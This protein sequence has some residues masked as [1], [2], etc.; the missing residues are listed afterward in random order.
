MSLL[1]LLHLPLPLHLPRRFQPE[2]QSMSM[3]IL[4][5]LPWNFNGRSWKCCRIVWYLVQQWAMRP[6]LLQ[7]LRLLPAAP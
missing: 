4:G 6:L 7:S 2:Q 3:K 5:A 1:H